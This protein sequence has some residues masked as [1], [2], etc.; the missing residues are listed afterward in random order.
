MSLSLLKA[1]APE[2]DVGDDSEDERLALFLGMATRRLDRSAWGAVYEDA[3]VYLAA[4]LLTLS[5]RSSTAGAGAGA[6]TG[7][8][9][10]DFSMS[11]APVMT[12]PGADAELATTVY[13]QQ[14]LALR[15]T[16]AA[17]APRLIKV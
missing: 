5:A 8:S 16:R 11:F 12:R 4:H 10:G 6:I 2:F 13:G 1:V 3:Q 14:F 15:S 7:M 17:G 9:T